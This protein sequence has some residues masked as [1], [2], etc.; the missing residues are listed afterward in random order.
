MSGVSLPPRRQMISA[1]VCDLPQPR[2]F[3]RTFRDTQRSCFHGS[4]LFDPR[5]RT[6]RLFRYA[7]KKLRSCAVKIP[8]EG[9]LSNLY[10]TQCGCVYLQIVLA[11]LVHCVCGSQSSAK[12]NCNVDSIIWNNQCGFWRKRWAADWMDRVQLILLLRRGSASAV[13]RLNL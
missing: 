13:C 2:L 8:K 3:S 10:L 12:V 7:D 4:G 5:R 1:F 9:G 11:L 6:D